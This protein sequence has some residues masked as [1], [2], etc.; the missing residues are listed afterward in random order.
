MY[1]GFL[2]IGQQANF[3]LSAQQVHSGSVWAFFA[4]NSL[5]IAVNS[6]NP[7]DSENQDRSGYL[8]LKVGLHASESWIGQD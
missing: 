8:P 4:F 7:L 3:L 5:L 1:H 6:C 2:D